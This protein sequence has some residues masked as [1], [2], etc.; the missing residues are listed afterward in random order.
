MNVK[1]LGYDAAKAYQ[2]YL[3]G[4]L[5][6]YDSLDDFENKMLD[7]LAKYLKSIGDPSIAK[8]KNKKSNV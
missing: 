8:F 6:K 7:D 5:M 4:K 1:K 3:I 2:T